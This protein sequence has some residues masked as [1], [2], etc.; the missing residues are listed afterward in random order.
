LQI[1]KNIIL[2]SSSPR[3][4]EILLKSGI[5]FEI[6]KVNFKE[7]V[8]TTF[9]VEQVPL[10]LALDKMDQCRAPKQ[11]EL[12]ITCDT[13]V[14]FRNN[15]LGKPNSDKEAF[16]TLSRL[17]SNTHHVISG[18]CLATKKTRLSFNSITEVTFDTIPEKA[19]R[20]YIE[21][22]SPFDKAGSYGIQD[23]FGLKYVK[24]IIGCY[25]NVMGLPINTL[26]KILANF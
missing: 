7:E 10:K 22:K 6:L 23:D 9:S 4:S 19:I 1:D 2:A 20:N 21:T 16:E 11:N 3:R 12:I 14:A 24:G 13:V 8:N 17:S 26:I 25:Y 15:V 5:D 18:V